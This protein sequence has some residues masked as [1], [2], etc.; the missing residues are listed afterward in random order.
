[1]WL[2]SGHR[3]QNKPLFR[4]NTKSS[5]RRAQSTG[6]E[7]D[8]RAPCSLNLVHFRFSVSFILLPFYFYL[9]T[10]IFCLY[11]FVF[12]LLLG[13]HVLKTIHTERNK[14]FLNIG[15]AETRIYF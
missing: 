15:D 10:F 8:Y 3:L 11:T 6:Q 13:Y 5:E 12:Y 4:E 7:V 2:M 9:F 1:M 14:R